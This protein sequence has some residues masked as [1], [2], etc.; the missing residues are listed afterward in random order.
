M[1]FGNLAHGHGKS[2]LAGQHPS[3]PSPAPGHWPAPGSME[4]GLS[5]PST[6]RGQSETRQSGDLKGGWS[7]TGFY[8]KDSRRTF[9]LCLFFSAIG[10]CPNRFIT[11]SGNMRGSRFCQRCRRQGLIKN[12]KQA[13]QARGR[14]RALCLVPGKRQ[15]VPRKCRVQGPRPAGILN[16]LS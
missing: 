7:G 14:R 10:V 13:H 12:S 4:D 3:L 11:P 16:P 6:P 8:S 15:P 9:S 5:S 1:I 2:R